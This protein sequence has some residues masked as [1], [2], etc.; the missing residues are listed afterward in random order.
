MMNL[1]FELGLFGMVDIQADYFTEYRSNILMDRAQTPSTL[2]L[3]API[4][5]NVGEASSKGLE[6]TID[7]K[8]DFRNDLF[9]SARAN[10]SYATSKFEVYDELDYVSAGLPWRSRIGLNLSQPFGYIA[11]RLFIDEAD[12][13]NS[14][15]AAELNTGMY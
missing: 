13:A 6:F 10:F 11:E 3:Q 4:R 5:A 12:I 1:G 15:N 14:A 9:I 2:G 7:Y 8:Q